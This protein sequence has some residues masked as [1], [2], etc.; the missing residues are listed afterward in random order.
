MRKDLRQIHNLVRLKR[1]AFYPLL[2]LFIFRGCYD[3]CI[4]SYCSRVQNRL[5]KSAEKKKQNKTK[6]NI[7][8]L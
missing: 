4:K 3:N 7:L 6:E 2:I 5:L 8:I 1:L